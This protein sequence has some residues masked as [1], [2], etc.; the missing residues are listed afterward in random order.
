MC[1]DF[2]PN[3]NN[4][5]RVD[6]LQ[7]FTSPIEKKE[8]NPK[9]KMN[10]Y[11][12]SEARG[13]DFLVL[14]LDCDKEGE[15]ICFEVID[16]V[17][18]VL[19]K[20]RLGNVMDVI[21]RAHFSAVTE[22]D[23]KLAMRNL[24]RPNINE[25]LSVDARQELDLRIGCAFT[26]FQTRYFQGKYGDLDSATI[27]FGP[28]QTPTLGFC[29]TRH[30]QITQ[31]KP[32]PYWI[33]EAIFETP[34]GEFLYPKHSRGRIF[35]KDVSELFLNRI[36]KHD[37][38]VVVDVVSSESRR[39]R[40]HALNTVELLR[41]CSSGLGLSPA[42]TMNT[43]EYLYTRG[44]IS[45]PRTETT[46]YSSNFDFMEALHHQ[47]NDCRWKDVVRKLISEGITK[48]RAGEDKG[49]HPPITPLCGDDGSL[50][51]DAA[52]VYEYITQHFIATLMNPCI[53]L[54]STIKI[55]VGEEILTATSRSVIDAGYT[56]IMTWQGIEDD[57][58]LH[59][60]QK[61]TVLDMKR[62]LVPTKLGIALVHGYW[63]IDPE[64]VLPT[65][66]GEVESQLNLIAKGY[67]DF[68]AVST[69]NF[70]T[71]GF[72]GWAFL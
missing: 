44:F 18:H 48:P 39:E 32:E 27:S 51:G 60:V 45:Y 61:G 25:S 66:R 24:G 42:Q 23:I 40:P 5:E 29:V 38:G 11:L 17:R 67:A 65:M 59:D 62:R 33:I 16:A 56:E 52:R 41:V 49:D 30:D 34:S 63:K 68:S 21:Y 54:V 3:M 8:A 43:A 55:E 50:A 57:A 19:K 69:M 22:K 2:P 64:L 31:F 12:A 14:W 1:A 6:P 46:A 15:N 13:C 28:C 10:E 35:D 71:V 70:N 47:K 9:M 20:P 26:R 4:W 58:C 36:K 37:Q 53:Y 7:L 72:T